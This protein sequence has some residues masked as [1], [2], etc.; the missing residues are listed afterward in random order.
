MDQVIAHC[1][2][3][4]HSR[5]EVMGLLIGDVY[6]WKDLTFTSVKNVVSTDLNSTNISVRFNREGFEGLFESLENLNY[7]YIIVGWYHS[8]PGMGCFMSAKDVETQKRMFTMPYHTA[9]VVDP[10]R[11][12]TKAYKLRNE[13][14]MERQFAVYHTEM[15]QHRGRVDTLSF[16]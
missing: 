5:L 1:R 6:R 11:G 10:I 2:A 4:A 9:L 12:E 13:G 16:L 14:Y 7:D 8:H 15:D 3:H